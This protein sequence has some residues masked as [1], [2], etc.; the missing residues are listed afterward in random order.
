MRCTDG[1]EGIKPGEC[2]CLLISGM[3]GPLMIDIMSRGS[4]RPEDFREV[5][6]SPQ[7]EVP[8]VRRWLAANG[9]KLTAEQMVCDQDK[10]YV[11]LKA[12]SGEEDAYAQDADMR[13][14]QYAYGPHLIKN[15]DSVL[16]DFLQQE[17]ARLDAAIAAV[18]RSREE[19]AAR[20]EQ[21]LEAQKEAACSV[22]KLWTI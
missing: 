10:Y 8:M 13:A 7:S 17:I 20:R 9:L 18:S 1:L 5:I 12:V 21:E 3:G 2:D 14:V 11:I 4:V 6:L 16:A 15:R 19:R 22:M